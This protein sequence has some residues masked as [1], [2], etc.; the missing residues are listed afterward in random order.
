[1]AGCPDHNVCGSCR[2]TLF[3]KGLCQIEPSRP[4]PHKCDVMSHVP[5]YP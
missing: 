1:V 2:L 3:G 4:L 5:M